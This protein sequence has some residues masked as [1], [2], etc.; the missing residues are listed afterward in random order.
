MEKKGT[1]E[2]Q[3]NKC[4]V[5]IDADIYVSLPVVLST[6]T[7]YEEDTQGQHKQALFQL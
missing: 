3:I 1:A 7:W 2:N 6:L 5:K 4:S